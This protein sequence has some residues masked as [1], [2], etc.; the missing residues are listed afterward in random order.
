MAQIRWDNAEFFAEAEILRPADVTGKMDLLDCEAFLRGQIWNH[1]KLVV[2][3]TWEDAAGQRKLFV[4]N[5]GETE[6]EV[7]LSVYE[8]EYNLP[9]TVEGFQVTDGFTLLGQ[10][11]ENGIRKLHCRIAS[12]GY[13][14]L[15]W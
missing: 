3:G 13:G 9:E 11:S 12:E 14:V 4:V 7:T 10:E 6:A 15:S 5:A 8:N 2:T 1:E